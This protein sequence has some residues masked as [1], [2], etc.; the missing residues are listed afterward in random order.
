MKYLLIALSVFIPFKHVQ[1]ESL[2]MQ[3]LSK[4]NIPGMSI[5]GRLSESIKMKE[6]EFEIPIK[7]MKT[8]MDSRD[9]HMYEEIFKN[10]NIRLSIVNFKECIGKESC[11]AEVN[12][13]ITGF[14]KKLTIPVRQKEDVKL[15]NFTVKLTDF[16]IHPPKKFGVQVEDQ[17][18][19]R[20]EVT[21]D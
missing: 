4:T 8:G 21:K 20:I 18:E 11:A 16:Q 6:S 17:V 12:L 2:H 9:E 10:K 1:A 13:E 3:F 15:A 19:V 5:E 14:K 7:K